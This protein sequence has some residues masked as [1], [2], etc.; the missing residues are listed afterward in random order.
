MDYMTLHAGFA[1]APVLDSCSDRGASRLKMLA[2]LP[3]AD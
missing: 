1:N 3:L 2:P